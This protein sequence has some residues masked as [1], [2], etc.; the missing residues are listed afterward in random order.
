MIRHVSVISAALVLAGCMQTA[1]TDPHGNRI[2]P[3]IVGMVDS[4]AF[5]NGVPPHIAQAVVRY[6]SGYRAHARSRAG[7]LGLSQIKCTTARGIGFAGSCRELFNAST[8][9]Q[10]G[11]KYLRMALDKG[12]EGCR[13]ISLYNTG[14]YARARCTSYGRAVSRRMK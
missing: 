9:L 6:E 1:A 5:A 11:M 7:A 10:W 13:G 14:L 4:A 12:G 2:D 8:N 3:V